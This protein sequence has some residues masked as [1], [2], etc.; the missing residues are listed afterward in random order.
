[1]SHSLE[2]ELNERFSEYIELTKVG[3][4]FNAMMNLVQIHHCL[5]IMDIET[6]S[7]W[8]EKLKQARPNEEALKAAELAVDREVKY[9]ERVLSIGTI[10]NDD[11]I[12]LVLQQ[13]IYID[14]FLDYY[15]DFTGRD[16]PISVSKADELIV[17]VARTKENRRSYEIAIRL[18]KKNWS[19]VRSKWLDD[20]FYWG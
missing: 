11:E 8:S 3:M 1:M 20:K 5:P 4:H 9:I 12:L 2:K 19:F 15:R 17:S 14:M 16:V 6:R 13:R 7:K 18:M 10:W